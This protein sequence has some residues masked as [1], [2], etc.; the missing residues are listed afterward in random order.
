MEPNGQG[1]W[2]VPGIFWFMQSCADAGGECNKTAC[3]PGAMPGLF[4][5]PPWCAA[6]THCQTSPAWLPGKMQAYWEW[7]QAEPAIQ[8]FNPWHWSDR[9]S[10]S[11]TDGFARG[12]VSLGAELRQ[13]YTGLMHG[14]AQA[15]PLSLYARMCAE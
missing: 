9:I 11:A 5:G 13:W 8:G 10:M 7:A 12:A 1:L 3:C 6:G 15:D 2:V 14:L 4:G